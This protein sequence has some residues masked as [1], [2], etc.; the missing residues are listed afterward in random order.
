MKEHLR[1]AWNLMYDMIMVSDYSVGNRES[2]KNFFKGSNNGYHL[3]IS[4]WQ[5]CVQ[6][7]T[8]K[9]RDQGDKSVCARGNMTYRRR[10]VIYLRNHVA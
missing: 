4:L 5:Q 6:M 10:A 1:E 9:G 2:L 7:N 8:E 3:Q